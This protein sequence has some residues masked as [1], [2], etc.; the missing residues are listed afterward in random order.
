MSLKDKV[1]LITGSTTGIGEATAKEC[2]A[3]GAKVMLH[4]RCEERAKVVK[5]ALGDA[6]DYCIADLLEPNIAEA[7]IA[8]TVKAF[9]RIDVLVNNAGIYPRNNIDDL[10]EDFYE[11][12]MT[13]NFKVPL[14][15]THHAV[16][17]FRQVGGGVVVNIGSINAHCGQT[18]LLVYSASKGALMTM[19]RNLGDAL[20]GENIRVNQI[21]VGWTLTDSE[22]ALKTR[23]GFPEGWESQLPDFFAPTGQ[24]VR[25]EHVAHHVAFWASDASAPASGQ[26]YE[27][28]QYPLV[29]RNLLNTIDFDSMK[30][31]E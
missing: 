20:H 19:T 22:T 13:V 6:A 3:Q 25:P 4:G 23:E 2:I 29:G 24:L 14:F 10:T 16:K 17:Q 9:G 8:A 5:A 27:L 7:L 28:E 1:V 21:N 12:M 15:L 31:E 26:V 18:D 30:T 11:R